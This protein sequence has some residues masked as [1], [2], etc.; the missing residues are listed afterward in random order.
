M[1]VAGGVLSGGISPSLDLE[2]ATMAYPYRV[3][4]TDEQR[5]KL[6]SLIGTGLA[7]ARTLTA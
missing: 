7:L 3:V 5:A 1:P 2:D 6:W 4:L